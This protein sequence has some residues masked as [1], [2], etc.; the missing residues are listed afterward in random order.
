MPPSQR[1]GQAQLQLNHHPPPSP[2][3][4]CP[5]V[6]PRGRLRAR[7]QRLKQEQKWARR[8]TGTQPLPRPS[9]RQL[10]WL[11]QKP[12]PRAQW[13]AGPETP[14]PQLAGWALPWLPQRPWLPPPRR[15]RLCP[16]VPVR[17]QRHLERQQ[18]R[19]QHDLSVQA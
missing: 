10:L 17:G 7:H 4:R 11:P 9:W 2:T 16:H 1:R 19:Q 15:E 14:R 8:A 3:S 13:T 12:Q 18:R 6:A 5:A